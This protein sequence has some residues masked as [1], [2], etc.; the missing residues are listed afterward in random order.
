MGL[1]TLT[2]KHDHFPVE[3]SP[4]YQ[5]M[6]QRNTTAM[7]IAWD[8][9]LMN[10]IDKFLPMRAG[11]RRSPDEPGFTDIDVALARG[12]WC[13]EGKVAGFGASIGIGDQGVYA[14]GEEVYPHPARLS[15]PANTSQAVKRA[16]RFLGAS[17][18]GIADYDERWVYTHSFHPFT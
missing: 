17:L 16:A 14:W 15:N 11:E 2:Q 10:Q 18:V 12:S 5:R 4:D 9:E 8:P 13:V 6:D 3:V 7:R 1:I